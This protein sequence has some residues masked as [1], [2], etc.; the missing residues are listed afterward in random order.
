MWQ[1]RRL[2]IRRRSSTPGAPFETGKVILISAG[3]LI[4]DA[5][6]AFL[7]PLIP[8][9]RQKLALSNALAG[10]LATFLRSSSLAQPFIGY[11]A[12][13]TNARW[14][15]ILA[16]STTAI[17][18]SL[19]GAAPSYLV[20]AP[21]L[22]LTGLSHAGYHAPAPAMIAHVSGN[23]IG[24]GMSF[25]MTGGELGRAFG[26]LLIVAAV[27]IFGLEYSVVAALPGILYSVILARLLGGASLEIRQR[28]GFQ[29]RP[30]LAARRRP[31]AILLAFIAIRSLVIG[32][33]SVFTP[34]YLTARGMT[35]MQAS[36][37]YALMELAGAAGAFSGGTLSDRLGRR[38]MILIIQALTVPFFV[39][40]ATGP[41]W[42]LTPFL[43]LTGFL[44]F[45]GTPVLLALL[46]ELLPEVRSTASGL[47]FSVNYVLTGTSAILFGLAADAWG[48]QTAF[49]LLAFAPWLT[50]PLACL[51]PDRPAR[52]QT[53]TG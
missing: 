10:S 21:L 31:L 9:L 2:Q 44:V 50:L 34:A 19:V 48:I 12:D 33:L 36:A 3:H 18:M 46:Q 26:P 7:A 27:Q 11:M 47:Y 23:R 25:F 35:L 29:L 6:P 30:L 14:L 39:T 4:H 13:R 24:K 49:L 41:A 40:L 17:F 51:L 53:A 43:V 5:Y 42:L 38:R 22:V 32:S 1:R 16:P 15:V 8:L 37:G 45:G 20:A 52:S 28:G